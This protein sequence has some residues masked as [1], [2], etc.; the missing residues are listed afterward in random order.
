MGEE[1][2]EE[3]AEG[4]RSRGRKGQ[5]EGG[6]NWGEEQRGREESIVRQVVDL[7]KY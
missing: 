2:R 3:G 5:R 6:A 7:T 4:G 1:P